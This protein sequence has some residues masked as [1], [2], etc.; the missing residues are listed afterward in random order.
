MVKITHPKLVDGT[1]LISVW[2]SDGKVFG[3]K[4][5]FEKQHCLQ[6]DV[7]GMNSLFVNKKI[8]LEGIIIPECNWEFND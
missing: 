4:H 8:S 2:F 1:Y 6:L 5:I 7:S 3:G